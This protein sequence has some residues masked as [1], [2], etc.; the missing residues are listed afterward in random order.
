[1][2]ARPTPLP[3]VVALLV[4]FLVRGGDV[5]ALAARR[6]LYQYVQEFPGLHLREIARGVELDPNHA[7][8]HL[9]YLERHG[10]VSSRREGGYWR[11]FARTPGPLGPQE[12]VAPQDKRVLS[13][14]RRPYPLH[15]TLLLLDLGQA[16]SESLRST[17]GVSRSTLQY[18]LRNMEAAGLLQSRREGRNRIYE[19]VR[20]EELLGH[21]LRYRPPDGLVQSFLEAWEQLEFP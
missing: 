7:K 2:A 17:M 14:L 9:S 5:L 20:P 13:I 16:P 3:V 19:L 6:R 18:H 15:V 4:V 1:M 8:Y 21:L 12:V 10:L 11:F